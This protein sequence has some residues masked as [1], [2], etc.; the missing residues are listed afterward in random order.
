MG[1]V[2]NA[3][4]I[5]LQAD[6]PVALE[7]PPGTGKTRRIVAIAKALAEAGLFDKDVAEYGCVA[8]VASQ[9][10]PVDVGGVGIPERDGDGRVINV[11]RLPASPELILAMKRRVVL[12]LDEISQTNPTMQAP[13]MS[14][15][16]ERRI[17]VNSFNEATR[18]AMAFNPVEMAAGGWLFAAP[19]ANRICFLKDAPD[20]ES[21]SNGMMFG[22]DKSDMDVPLLPKGWEAGIPEANALAVGFLNS[23]DNRKHWNDCPK[24]DEVKASGPW[25]SSRS[26]D[27]AMRLLAAARAVDASKAVQM[28]LVGGCIGD[29]VTTKFF[30]YVEALDL[31]NPEEW[32]KDP[33][34]VKV[35]DRG[36]RAFVSANGVVLAVRRKLT[37]DRWNAAWKVL[38][39]FTKAGKTDVAAQAA[40]GLLTKDAKP[41]GAKPVPE[42]KAYFPLMAKAGMFKDLGL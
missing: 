41:V 2:E 8:W 11:A 33:D 20:F 34:S 39:A 15:V 36:D 25:P 22:F 28:N 24:N 26:W 17:G 29:N 35:P 32:L 21:W 16:Q 27:N 18:I 9:N 7:G 1:H 40:K 31:P 38:A 13:I 6:V 12:F 19:F 23:A 4:A 30:T 5:A 42:M 14:M 3:L 10:D 37:L